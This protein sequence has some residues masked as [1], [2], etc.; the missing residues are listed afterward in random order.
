M[1]PLTKKQKEF[2]LNRNIKPGSFYMPPRWGFT[3]YTKPDLFSDTV[4]IDCNPFTKSLDH[5][6]ISVKG[7]ENDFFRCNM[8]D[9]PMSN[10]FYLW[11]EDFKRRDKISVALVFLLTLVPF[12][13]WNL[14]TFNK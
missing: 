1:E 2:I 13:I 5:A 14:I 12:L 6:Y 10:D 4:D 9:K 11:H 8:L 7:I 3:V